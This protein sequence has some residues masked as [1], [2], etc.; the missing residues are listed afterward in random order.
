MTNQGKHRYVILGAGRQ[1]TAAAYDLVMRGAAADVLMCDRDGQVAA[2]SAGRVNELCGCEV[3][4]HRSVDVTDAVEVTSALRDATVGLSAVPYYHNLAI[5]RIAIAAGTSLVDMGGHTETVR[6]QLDLHADAV[7]A[8]VVVLPDCG[9]G[10]GLVN[11]LAVRVMQIL[12]ETREIRVCDAGLPQHPEPPWRYLCAFNINGLTNEYDGTVPLLRDGKIVH[13]EA[14]SECEAFEI[15]PLGKLEGFI[16]AGG[17]TAP[18]TFEGR[19]ATF[20]TRILRYPGHWQQ[21]HA[22]KQLGL[23]SEE[24]LEVAGQRVVP[25]DVYHALLAP[26]IMVERFEDICVMHC[27]GRGRL[28][29]K[30]ATALIDV[31]DR[32]DPQ[33]GFTGMERLTGWHCAMMMRFVA[34]GRVPA[35]ARALEALLLEGTPSANEVLDEVVA[36]GIEV[37]SQVR[38]AS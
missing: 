27:E 3:A 18:W 11:V 16:A 36:R 38:S 17:S 22:Y 4:R 28:D 9:M 20:E 35:G 6:H 13:V 21:F 25:R 31:V 15:P 26:H 23:F 33:T 37:R 34:D 14:L 8:G 5:S 10:P 7:E 29:G 12:D 24:P 30:A 19:L 32:F 1:G 2:R